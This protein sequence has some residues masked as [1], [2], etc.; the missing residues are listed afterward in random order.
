MSVRMAMALVILFFSI[1]S[2]S[3]AQ[4]GTYRGNA[5]VYYGVFDFYGNPLGWYQRSV[6]VNVTVKSRIRVSGLVEPSSYNISI[7]SSDRSFGSFTLLSAA[8]ARSNPRQ[9]PFLASYW[10]IQYNAR[11]KQFSG[12]LIEDQRELGLVAN[13]LWAHYQLFPGAS[14]TA[15]PFN[16]SEGTSLTGSLNGRTIRFEI[17][18]DQNPYLPYYIEVVATK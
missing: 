9:R 2:Q 4:S 18:S 1:T 3:Y 13:S 15:Y 16:M 11:S 14:W 10:N 7:D 6:P 8:S 12:L 17:E 5:S